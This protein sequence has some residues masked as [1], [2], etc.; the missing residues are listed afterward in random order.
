MQGTSRK[1]G[2]GH[3]PH[4][5]M[6]AESP[7]APKP[8]SVGIGRPRV[9]RVGSRSRSLYLGTRSLKAERPPVVDWWPN[10][11]KRIRVVFDRFLTL[12]RRGPW[13]EPLGT[14]KPPTSDREH[15]E[16]HNKENRGKPARHGV[17]TFLPCRGGPRSP[18]ADGGKPGK[19]RRPS[20]GLQDESADSSSSLTRF[21]DVRSRT[22]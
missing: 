8:G 1:S 17:Q 9:R 11:V 19:Y 14:R 15:Q 2:V 3:A 7:A 5:T 13:L 12:V 18:W 10:V 20:L 16:G 6:E 21:I 4:G 22:T